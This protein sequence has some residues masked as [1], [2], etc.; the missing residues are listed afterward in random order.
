MPQKAKRIGL[1]WEKSGYGGVWKRLVHTT[2]AVLFQPSGA[3]AAM[4]VRG[5]HLP[6]LIYCIIVGWACSAVASA[7]SLIFMALDFSPL[8]AW[9]RMAGIDI[10]FLFQ[11]EPTIL[12]STSGALLTLAFAPLMVAIG[13]YITT[14]IHHLFLMM[15]RGAN[16]GFEATLRVNAYASGATA[17]WIVIPFVGNFICFFWWLTAMIIGLTRAHETGTGKAVFAMLVPMLACFCLCCSGG[18]LL[19]MLGAIPRL[20]R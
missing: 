18:I 16:A 12:K 14:A 1:P 9:S 3:F 6:P 8:K 4:Q 20:M 17:V 15:I 19:A 5:G 13:L 2:K 7:W 11:H 10:S